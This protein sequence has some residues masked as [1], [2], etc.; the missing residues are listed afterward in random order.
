MFFPR[1]VT[2]LRIF[3]AVL[4]LICCKTGRAAERPS[5]AL[6][7][8]VAA[9]P[10]ALARHDGTFLYWK[11][12][13]RMPVGAPDPDKSFEQRLR[14]PSILDQFHQRYPA[15]APVTAPAKDF[16]PGRF[17]NEAF[18]RKLY[19]DCRR[20]EVTPHLTSVRWFPK[21]RTVEVTRLHGVAAQLA[22]V[23]AEIDRLPEAIKQATYPTAGTYACRTVLDTGLTSVH[24]YAAAIDL[25]LSISDYWAWQSK[26]GGQEPRYRNR[27]PLEIVEIFE[28]HGFIWGGRWYHYD[29]MHFEYRPELLP[30]ARR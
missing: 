3:C 23:A 6:D 2:G 12:G 8:L 17:R 30:G 24:A 29:T 11:D 19:G 27:M 1:A 25:N 22:K 9:Y 14:A 4:C 26:P 10:D 7:A 21:G 5:D 28:R 18:F 16:D 20:G 13:T 15:G